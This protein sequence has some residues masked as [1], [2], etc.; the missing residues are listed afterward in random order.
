MI[1]EGSTLLHMRERWPPARRRSLPSTIR[2]KTWR[3]YL[4]AG[5]AVVAVAALVAVWW[6]RIQDIRRVGSAAW[7]W[8]GL[9]VLGAVVWLG[10][11]ALISAAVR[12]VR[13]RRRG[14]PEQDAAQGTERPMLRK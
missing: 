3:V 4:Y 2:E 8:I 12:R 1:A 7:I 5:V 13:S 9:S 14:R 11:E 6:R 10:S